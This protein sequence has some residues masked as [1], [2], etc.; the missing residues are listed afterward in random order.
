MNLKSF[1]RGTRLRFG[2]VI[3]AIGAE[4]VQIVNGKITAAQTFIG[5]QNCSHRALNPTN[6][7]WPP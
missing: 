3:E 6:P 2:K 5:P 7:H 1:F 4:V